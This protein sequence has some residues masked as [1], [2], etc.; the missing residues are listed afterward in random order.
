LCGGVRGTGPLVLMR[1]DRS[2]GQEM[3]MS[4]ITPLPSL[5]ARGMSRMT[6]TMLGKTRSSLNMSSSMMSDGR[7][8]M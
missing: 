3:E 5:N 4:R 8:C 1:S 7:V 2:R 6:S